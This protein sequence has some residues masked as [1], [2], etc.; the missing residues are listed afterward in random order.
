MDQSLIH[1]ALIA[2]PLFYLRFASFNAAL[3]NNGKRIAL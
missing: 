2:G 3:V 1:A